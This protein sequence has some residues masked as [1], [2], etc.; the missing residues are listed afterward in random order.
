MD[1][2]AV[3]SFE[4]FLAEVPDTSRREEVEGRLEALRT[5]VRRAERQEAQAAAERERLAREAREAEERAARAAAGGRSAGAEAPTVFER[6]WF[7]AIVGAVVAGGVTA[8]LVATHDPGT[9]APIPGTGGVVVMALGG[10]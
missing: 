1:R 8:A 5:A 10:P 7:W 6:W 2:E 9:E 4:R 3:A